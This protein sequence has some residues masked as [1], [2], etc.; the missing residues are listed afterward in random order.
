MQNAEGT[1]Q[2]ETWA[3]C[4]AKCVYTLWESTQPFC[5]PVK[6][7]YIKQEWQETNIL[8]SSRLVNFANSIMKSNQSGKL[9]EIRC[10]LGALDKPWGRLA[11]LMMGLFW[12]QKMLLSKVG[13]VQ[14]PDALTMLCLW[15]LFITSSL[16]SLTNFYRFNIAPIGGWLMR[17]KW[18][19]NACTARRRPAWLELTVCLLVQPFCTQDTVTVLCAVATRHSVSA[20]SPLFLPPSFLIMP[21]L[22][23]F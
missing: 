9:Y 6:E 18:L 3:I 17:S 14:V 23:F 19:S 22:S 7:P 2:Q 1:N 15:T 20:L 12:R 8:P 4:S 13:P 16:F 21:P 10:R 5:G 11:G